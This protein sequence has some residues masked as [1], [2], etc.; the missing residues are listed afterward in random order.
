VDGIALDPGSRTAAVMALVEAMPGAT[1]SRGTAS[2]VILYKVMAKMF[3]ILS[4]R[5][6][7]FVI[8]KCDPY[9]A[10][11]LREQYAGVGHRSHRS[12]F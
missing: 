11:M 4:V 5:G 7:E 1:A 8:L 12:D 10:E 9:R 3:A 2:L 6:A